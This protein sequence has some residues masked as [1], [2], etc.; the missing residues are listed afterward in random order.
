MNG[1]SG[2]YGK[3]PSQGDFIQHNLPRGFIDSWDDWLALVL[4]HSKAQ[5]GDTWLETYL[6][7]PIYR[8]I[9]TPGICG[10]D[11]FMGVVMPSVDSVGRYY[12]FVLAATL[13]EKQNPFHL[14]QQQ[15]WFDQAQ[16]LILTTL[17]DNFDRSQF[18]LS[19]EGLDSLVPKPGLADDVISAASINESIGDT[20]LIRSALPSLD[21][22]QAQYPQLMHNILSETCHAYSLWWTDGSENISP[23]FLISQGLPPIKSATSLLAGGWQQHGWT[24]YTSTTPDSIDHATLEN[25][26]WES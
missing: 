4:S 22:L 24:E 16:N 2:Y 21:Q 8:F 7:S 9:L 15:E 17:D 3:T 1:T 10:E 18:A 25:E 14:L 6:T 5:L 26:P 12:P 13:D 20:L 11:I 23:S 19:I